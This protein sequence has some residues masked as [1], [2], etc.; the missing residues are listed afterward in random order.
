MTAGSTLDVI[1]DDS[2]AVR[3]CSAS[4]KSPDAYVKLDSKWNFCADAT[5]AGPTQEALNVNRVYHATFETYQ[6]PVA[7]SRTSPVEVAVKWVRGSLGVEKL[8]YEASLYRGKLKHLQAD[9]VPRFYGLYAGEFHNEE[10][11]CLVL[12]WCNNSYSLKREEL[13]RRRMSA[14]Y[15]LHAAGIVHGQLRDAGHFLYSPDGRVRIVDFSM[16]ELHHCPS[17]SEGSVSGRAR[18]P[19]ICGELSTMEVCLGICSA[20]WAVIH[21]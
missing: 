3:L 9:V 19:E 15:R 7:R 16:A 5:P 14:I 17:H 18:S 10:V 13:N 21:V 1:F 11:G 8:R 6:S 2:T 4:K 20:G 12:E